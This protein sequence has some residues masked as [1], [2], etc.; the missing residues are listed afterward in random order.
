M[1]EIDIPISSMIYAY[2]GKDYNDKELEQK[3]NE[4]IEKEK[5]KPK[6]QMVNVK[7]E[8]LPKLVELFK[9]I[10]DHV[11]NHIKLTMSG[12]QWKITRHKEV[13]AYDT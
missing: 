2:L 12:N 13:G 11:I 3:V 4:Y 1:E 10:Q 5:Q 9:E 7:E 8:D 6:P